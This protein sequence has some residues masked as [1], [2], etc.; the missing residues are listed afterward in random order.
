MDNEGADF[1]AELLC[2][3]RAVLRNEQ[4]CDDFEDSISEALYILGVEEDR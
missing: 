4:L 3:I 1:V 2:E